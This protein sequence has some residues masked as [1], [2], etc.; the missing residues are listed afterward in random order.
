[1]KI[2][3]P[4]RHLPVGWDWEN[5]WPRLILGHFA[6]GLPLFAFLKR[7]ADARAVLY[8]LVERPD[9]SGFYSQYVQVLDPSRTIAPFGELIGGTPLLG[10]W[11]FLAAMPLVVWRYYEFHA[12]GAM[13]VY[14]MRRLPDPWEYHRRCWVL[15]IL[16]ALAEIAL[17]ALLIGLCWLL[18]WFATPLPCRPI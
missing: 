11:L 6:S 15:P 13:S 7:Y 18:W 17:Y 16:S 3:D 8:D 9:G 2:F 10:L 12:H 4:K 1:M 14:T 5:T